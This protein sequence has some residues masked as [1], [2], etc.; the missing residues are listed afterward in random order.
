MGNSKYFL[1]GVIA[2]LGMAWI[3]TAQAG[4]VTF[5]DWG[6]HGAPSSW[7]AVNGVEGPIPSGA[8]VALFNRDDATDGANSDPNGGRRIDDVEANG[9]KPDFIFGLEVPEVPTWVMMGLGFV[10]LGFAAF[11]SPRKREIS[12]F[13]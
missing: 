12:P 2:A 5:T 9:S 11:R 10:G 13:S 7:T 4:V 8:A 1:G 3:A 6:G